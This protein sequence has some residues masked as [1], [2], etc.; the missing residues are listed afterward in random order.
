M[1][2]G[3]N[4]IAASDI[5]PLAVSIVEETLTDG[6]SDALHVIVTDLFGKHATDA[7]VTLV[8]ATL[9]GKSTSA[10]PSSP[11]TQSKSGA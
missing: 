1:I 7:S 10:V 9:G 6:S 8:S 4:A 5:A 11:F 3:L 2:T